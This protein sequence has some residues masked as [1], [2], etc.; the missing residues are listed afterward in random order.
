MKRA[1]VA[2][3]TV[4]LLGVDAFVIARMGS[5]M[6]AGQIAGWSGG[7]LFALA[8]IASSLYVGAL[9]ADVESLPFPQAVFLALITES[10]A[11]VTLHLAPENGVLVR[12][13]L[14]AAVGGLPPFLALTL[15]YRVRFTRA[16]GASV[17][18]L[19]VLGAILLVFSVLVLGGVE[20]IPALLGGENV[21]GL[22]YDV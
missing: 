17:A 9:L 3:V 6:T 5:H 20:R 4:A 18:H 19:A 1:I 12:L 7:A 10:I 15:R 13:A 11:I 2:I 16:A 8:A 21:F 22:E 14:L